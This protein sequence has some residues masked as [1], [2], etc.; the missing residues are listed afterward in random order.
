MNSARNCLERKGKKTKLKFDFSQSVIACAEECFRQLL[1][2]KHH[3]HIPQMLVDI[4]R[5]GH[6]GPFANMAYR[7]LT[8]DEQAEVK[9]EVCCAAETVKALDGPYKPTVEAMIATRYSKDL[10]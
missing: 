3:Q 8:K 10:Q 1:E 2:P 6:V 4:Q 9:R 7:K 5:S